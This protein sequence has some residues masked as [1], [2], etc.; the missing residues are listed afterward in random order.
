MVENTISSTSL[1][2]SYCHRDAR[3]RPRFNSS[4]MG[5]LLA[6]VRYELGADGSDS[7]YQLVKDTEGALRTGDWIDD[8]IAEEIA[9]SDI[10]LV[11]LSEN[12]CRSSSCE[13]ELRTFIKLGKSL[14]LV[15]LDDHWTT[16]DDHPMVALRD[17]LRGLLSIRFWA[18]QAGK[19]VRFGHP[20]PQ[21]ATGLAQEG[22][23]QQ[24]Q[25]LVDDIKTMSN[26]VTD[27]QATA[28]PNQI[29]PS[30]DSLVKIVLAASTSDTKTETDR[31]ERVYLDAGFGVTRLDRVSE[32]LNA[33]AIRDHLNAAHIFVQ[34][35]GAIPGRRVADYKGLPSSVA[36]HGIAKEVGIEAA[37]WMP[38]GFDLAECGEDYAEFLR[39][40]VSH[41]SSFEDFEA[42]SV[43]LARKK[44]E[45]IQSDLRREEIFQS[46]PGEFPPL[47]SIDAARSD[48]VLRDKIGAAL[49][50]HVLVDYVDYNASMEA[51]SESVRD[52][53]AIVLVY[54]DQIEGQK[55]ARAHFRFFRRW[56]KAVWNE[57]QQR[58]E[59]AFGNAAP[60]DATPCPSGPGIH[61]IRISSDI[62]EVSMGAFLSSLGV[63]PAQ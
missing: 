48:A 28:A 33:A 9:K 38:R 22:Y 29:A 49:D 24:L 40:V 6:D 36:Q 57:E 26:S 53:D 19:S 42:Y 30:D 3:H 39:T 4:R 17:E 35:I 25:R 16:S 52:N 62:D 21:T 7:R 59:I 43:K 12:Y 8:K 56:R 31:L 63:Q 41:R 60:E 23:R 61:V 58:F 13:K 15:E 54:G 51:L 2:V 50:K 14:I 47:V 46:V 11:F 32:D 5:E 18:E 27:R 34:V 44:E 37:V 55:R 45:V 1:F 20:L 10:G